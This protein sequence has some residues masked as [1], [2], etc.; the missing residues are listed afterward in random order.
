MNRTKQKYPTELIWHI[1]WSVEI[2][3]KKNEKKRQT[4]NFLDSGKRNTYIFQME[5][6]YRNTS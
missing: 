6:I 2:V 3:W 5:H 4:A 1:V